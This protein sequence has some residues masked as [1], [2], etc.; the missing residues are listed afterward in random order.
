MAKKIK[1]GLENSSDI[2]L[3]KKKSPAK[4]KAAKVEQLHPKVD[5]KDSVTENIKSRSSKS[6]KD[7]GLGKITR[8]P[9]SQNLNQKPKKKK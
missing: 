7:A 5:N 8:V 2:K 9:L 3:P 4:P 6:V 1:D